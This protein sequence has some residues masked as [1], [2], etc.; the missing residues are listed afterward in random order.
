MIPVLPGQALPDVPAAGF[1]AEEQQLQIDRQH[2][3]DSE[4]VVAGPDA[5]TWTFVKTET[6]QN[7]Y[8]I[9]VP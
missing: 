1:D 9:P 4:D 5:S 7:L 6:R 2:V 8:R 3:L